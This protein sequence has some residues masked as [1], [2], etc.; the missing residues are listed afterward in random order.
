MTS[1]PTHPLERENPES[2][3]RL[4]YNQLGRETPEL[5]DKLGS[6]SDYSLAN[7]Y[8][9][10]SASEEQAKYLAAVDTM[11][12]DVLKDNKNA[13][14]VYVFVPMQNSS[15]SASSYAPNQNH[16]Q[17]SYS[18]MKSMYSGTDAVASKYS[19]PSASKGGGKGASK[20]KGSCSSK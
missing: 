13:N 18:N 5:I 9:R 20:G 7:E 6:N 19:G 11:I 10:N 1:T 8:F 12:R 14:I 15:Y 17:D 2:I 4:G 16:S 3:N